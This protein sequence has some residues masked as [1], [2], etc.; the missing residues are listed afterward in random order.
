VSQGRSR[1]D[2]FYQ[3]VIDDLDKVVQVVGLEAA[4]IPVKT[5]TKST[6]AAR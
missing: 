3:R 5:G 6:L 2:R 4:S 1:L